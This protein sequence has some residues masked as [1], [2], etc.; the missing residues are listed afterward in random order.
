MKIEQAIYGEVRRG[1]GLRLTSGASGVAAELTERLDLPDT[2]PAGVEWSPFLS[3]FPHREY[4]VVARTFADPEASRAGMVRTHALIA[5]LEE[6]AQT[7]DLRPLLGLLIESLQHVAVLETLELDHSDAMPPAAADL[8]AITDALTSKGPLPVVR[9]GNENFDALVVALWARLWPPF[10]RRFSCRLSFSPNDLVEHSKP[11][12]VCVPATLASR[13]SGFR[14]V[15]AAAASWPASLA[16]RILTGDT[17]EAAAVIAF[18]QEIGAEIDRLSDLPLL[19]Q[20]HKIASSDRRECSQ[21]VTALRLISLLSP[22]PAAGTGAKAD[23]MAELLRLLPQASPQDVLLLR[24]FNLPGIVSIEAAWSALSLWLSQNRFAEHADS[25]MCE[26]IESSSSTEKAVPVWRETVAQGFKAGMSAQSSALATAFWRWSDRAPPVAEIVL[27]FFP[28]TRGVEETLS[29]ACPK[30]LDAGR[31]D[32]ILRLAGERKWL[33]LHGTVA[34]AA[35]PPKDAVR[36]QLAVDTVASDLDGLKAALGQAAPLEVVSCAMAFGDARL[37]QL[38]AVR[39]ADDPPLLRQ[40]DLLN[41]VIQDVWAQAMK[42]NPNAW[43]GPSHPAAAWASLLDSLLG[44][45]T[46]DSALISELAKSPVADLCDFPRRS[47]VW[48][49]IEASARA[50]ALATTATGWLK[51]AA[52]GHLPFVPE[53]EFKTAISNSAQLDPSLAALIPTQPGIGLQIIAT[54]D[55]F[56]ELRFLGWLTVLLKGARSLPPPDAELLGQLILARRWSK[57]LD[58]LVLRLRCGR[59]DLKPSVRHCHSMLSLW[60]RYSLNLSRPSPEEKWQLLEEVAAELYPSGPDHDELWERARGKAQ[61]LHYGGSGRSRW[62]QV[63]EQMR[64]G[65]GFQ[66][67]KLLA[68]MRKD[69]PANEKLRTLAAEREFLRW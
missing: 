21:V 68:E 4:F 62:R 24:N 1:H 33:R 18:A 44:G 34:A 47:E 10:R 8:V 63:I 20:A 66:V 16:S 13:W 61:D 31:A 3:A 27:G 14:V 40:A 54:L 11:N 28:R 7:V 19:A 69:Y 55:G 60:E 29:G 46:V 41:P 58:L 15:T 23:L 9:L 50:E 25:G 17:A 53:A 48:R 65:S 26:I 30:R 67:G 43:Q 59:T 36:M 35:F 22:N 49:L 12:L 64:R 57:A 38:A 6:L 39:V 32:V 2:A 42:R 5:P 56:G 52:L 37:R 45:G 51:R